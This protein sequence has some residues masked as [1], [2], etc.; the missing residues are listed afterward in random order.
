MIPIHRKSFT[1]TPQTNTSVSDDPFDLNRFLD[2][3]EDS[4]EQALSELQ[5]GQKDSHWMWY[6]FPQFD[7]LG[8]SSMSRKYSIKSL[9]EAKAYLAHPVLGARLVECAETVLKTQGKSVSEIFGYPDDL[10]FHSSVTLFAQ[11]SPEDSVF[12]R[13]L[14]QCFEGKR[15]S[16]TLQ[17]IGKQ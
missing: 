8:M 16:R 14:M 1:M 12:H 11:V 17:I 9:N 2:A 10:K 7:G 15:D 3:Q 5:H 13:V 6:I 4:Y